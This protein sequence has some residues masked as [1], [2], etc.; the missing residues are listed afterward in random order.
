MV[1]VSGI[2]DAVGWRSGEVGVAWDLIEARLGTALPQDYKELCRV[3]SVRG[4]FS[5]HVQVYGAPGG[6]VSQVA[7]QLESLWRTVEA[8]PI[9]RGV[10][11]P[12]GLYRRGGS[13][14]FR[15]RRR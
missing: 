1:W 15:G 6:A 12:Y 4:E 5:G 7:D 13:G 14:L 8:H 10:Y 2:A 11:E 3:A 9:V